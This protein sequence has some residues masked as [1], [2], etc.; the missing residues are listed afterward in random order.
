VVIRACDPPLVD[1]RSE[2]TATSAGSALNKKIKNNAAPS[3]RIDHSLL[4]RRGARKTGSK[5]TARLAG[6]E[7][8]K[9]A[10]SG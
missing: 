7:E 8:R 1:A 9:I 3:V 10:P 2:R 6:N 4:T 5:D